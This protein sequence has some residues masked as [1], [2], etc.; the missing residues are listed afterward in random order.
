MS[1]G[2]RDVWAE[3]WAAVVIGGVV[4]FAVLGAAAILM[5]LVWA[6]QALRVVVG[7]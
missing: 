5:G 3:A 4:G 2:T 1:K 6:I 7:L